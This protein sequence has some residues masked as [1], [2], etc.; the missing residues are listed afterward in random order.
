MTKI[1]QSKKYDDGEDDEDDNNAIT[2]PL[3]HLLLP[4]L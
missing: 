2:S 4:S 3:H 1:Y